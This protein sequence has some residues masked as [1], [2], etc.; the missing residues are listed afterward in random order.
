MMC[1]KFYAI[2][3]LDPCAKVFGFQ[4]LKTCPFYC[5][6]ELGLRGYHHMIVIN[7]PRFGKGVMNSLTWLI[8]C[9][10]S[11]EAFATQINIIDHQKYCA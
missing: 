1:T 4:F 9:M 3:S 5:D 2:L 6:Y 8:T 7:E 10:L 11:V